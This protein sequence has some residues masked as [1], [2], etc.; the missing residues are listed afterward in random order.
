MKRLAWRSMTTPPS[1]ITSINRINLRSQVPA[2][3]PPPPE[4]GDDLLDLMDN[5]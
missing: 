5:A 4:E 3:P 2:P 1:Q